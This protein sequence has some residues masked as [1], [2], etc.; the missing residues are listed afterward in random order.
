MRYYA[1]TAGSSLGRA[2]SGL[3]A[4]PSR[5]LVEGHERGGSLVAAVGA[6]DKTR[7]GCRSGQVKW[8][9]ASEMRYAKRR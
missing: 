6:S 2:H 9:S 7:S 5:A 4:I 1:D 3:L 8:R